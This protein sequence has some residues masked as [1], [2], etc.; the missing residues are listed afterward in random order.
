MS[1]SGLLGSLVEARR[2]GITAQKSEDTGGLAVR[3]C[4]ITHRRDVDFLNRK[5][6]GFDEMWDAVHDGVA[7]SLCLA[8]QHLSGFAEL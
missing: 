7:N 5:R 3:E 2:A 6:A 1:A 4:W 8:D